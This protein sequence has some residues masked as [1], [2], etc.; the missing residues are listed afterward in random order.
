MSSPLD[1]FQPHL[2]SI[3][4]GCLYQ[5][6]KKNEKQALLM[7]FQYW[8]AFS[9]VQRVQHSSTAFEVC[10]LLFGGCTLINMGVTH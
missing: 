7:T 9:S 6:P 1:L 5:R 4:L 2:S 10:L 8:G 3:G